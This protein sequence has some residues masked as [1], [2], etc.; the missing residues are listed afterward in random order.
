M[1]YTRR[2]TLQHYYKA[3]RVP[4]GLKPLSKLSVSTLKIIN[5]TLGKPLYSSFPIYFFFF[6]I[7]VS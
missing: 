2:G 5:R 4:L 3:I 7:L 6:F 1:I